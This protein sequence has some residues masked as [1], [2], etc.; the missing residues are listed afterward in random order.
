MTVDQVQT[1]EGEPDQELG[2]QGPARILV[3]D[4]EPDLRL[5]FMQM[6]RR[7]LRAD[8]F[9]FEFVGNGREALE[10]M[11]SD[12][13]FD[14][15]L[16]D[17]RMPVMD[18]LSLLKELDERYPLIRVVMVTAY[19]DMENIRKAMNNGAF[20]F[21]SKPIQYKDLKTTI[22]KT[23]NAVAQIR[24]LHRHREE[25]RRAQQQL[26][27]E[28]RRIDRLKDEFLANTSHELR[29]PLY[30]IIGIVE[31]LITQA[32]ERYL[33][34]ET[35]HNLELILYSGRRLSA[36]INDL[37]DFSKLKNDDL[38]LRFK[39]IDL[40]SMANVVLRL[41]KPLIGIKKIEFVNDIPEDFPSVE[42]DEDRLQQVLFNLVGNAVKFTEEGQVR[43][44]AEAKEGMIHVWVSDTGIGIAESEK[45]RVF[46]AFHQADGSAS[47]T[48]GGT[49]IGLT[50]TKKLVELHGG[51]VTLETKPGEGSTFTFT[52]R[53]SGDPAEPITGLS[54]LT[55]RVTTEP[56]GTPEP[57]PH[58]DNE[59]KPF[60]ILLV[61]DD[62]VNLHILTNH[63]SAYH[64][65]PVSC[66]SE[67]LR[68]LN[69]GNPVDLV[70]LDVMMP[71]MSGIEVCE[72]IRKEHGQLDL[73]VIL[74][75][76]KNQVSDLVTGLESGANDFLTKPLSK[77]ELM[78]RV[79][80]HLNLLQTRRNLEEVQKRAL[81]HA[82]TAGKADF[83]TSVLHNVGNIL[84]SVNVSC[85]KISTQL[86]TS[87]IDGLSKAN[88]LLQENIDH[89]NYFLTKHEKGKQLPRYY[90]QLGEILALEKDHLHE[91]V[92][93]IEKRIHLMKDIIETQQFY[94]KEDQT[95]VELDLNTLVRE[96][97]AV[98]SASLENRH[99]ETQTNLKCK[100]PIHAHPTVLIHIFVNLIKNAAEAM[101]EVD[102]R[103]L[104]IQTGEDKG[105]P[106]AEVSD[107]GVG[108]KDL[109]RIFT[110]G[111]TTKTYGHGFGL[112]YCAKAMESMG[113]RLEVD[114]EGEMSGATFRLYFQKPPLGERPLA[115]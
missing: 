31:S 3:V 42:A 50:I 106:Y 26:V 66:G 82:R 20:D 79:N 65:V 96:S 84:N 9:S 15:V 77:A 76:A 95:L 8:E 54:S 2:W 75:T 21:V 29:T 43:I 34:H 11:E 88:R 110:K 49:G 46:E 99:V 109:S 68:Y 17:I 114:S 22:G 107:T 111:F 112:H 97:L 72:E 5:L 16:S 63:L 6:F 30:G 89:L 35:M 44:G 45:D 51:T 10:I 39:P 80:T 55:P 23:L 56:E 33:N 47:R 14:L 104:R 113:G 81:D 12:G 13:R 61:D 70:L 94:A 27:E 87:R 28:L 58:P 100:M 38:K 60:H 103:I 73:P 71:K 25:K 40:H 78:A 19:G 108:I 57:I 98:Q 64:V 37:L 32:D 74:L 7:E 53:P 105:M 102:N 41:S 93:R 86:R 92:Q 91:E 101:E 52:L 59:S 69:A 85:G 83:A 4:D 48:F 1:P 18:G 24:A 115:N 67:A 62:P 36:L 90:L